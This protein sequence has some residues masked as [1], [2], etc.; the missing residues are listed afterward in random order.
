MSR[1]HIFDVFP[2]IRD[3][4][5]EEAK[6]YKES[7]R[8]MSKPINKKIFN[9]KKSHIPDNMLPEG[10]YFNNRYQWYEYLVG[11]QKKPVIRATKECIEDAK[12]PYSIFKMFEK[13]YTETK[14]KEIEQAKEKFNDK[15]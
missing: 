12:N 15:N 2:G 11:Y 9:L 6:L 1:K 4:T 14:Y 13:T 8:N 7:I 5:K 10:W 3:F